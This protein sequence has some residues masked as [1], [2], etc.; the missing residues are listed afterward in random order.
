MYMY[1]HIWHVTYMPEPYSWAQSVSDLSGIPLNGIA[2]SPLHIW[3]HASHPSNLPLSWFAHRERSPCNPPSNYPR[4]LHVSC[5]GLGEQSKRIFVLS[6]PLWCTLTR[7]RN[8]LAS[9]VYPYLSLSQ[10]IIN[11]RIYSRVEV[12]RRHCTKRTHCNADNINLLWIAA[13]NVARNI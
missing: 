7:V 6:P 1:R 5:K 10:G 4:L 13:R 12:A 9:S 2:G 8:N 11:T 3:T